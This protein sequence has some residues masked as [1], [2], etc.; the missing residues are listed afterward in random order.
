MS[1][2][3]L[4]ALLGRMCAIAEAVNAFKSETVQQ[5]AFD[6]LVEAFHGKRAMAP[7]PQVEPAEE[8]VG[9]AEADSTPTDQGKS[10]VKKPARRK[11]SGSSA[12]GFQMVKELDLRPAGK[13][14]FADFIA[15]KQPGSNE[16]KYA[17]A[18]YYLQH[19]LELPTVTTN[20]VATV[21]RLESSWREPQDALKGLRVTSSRKGTV[22]VAAA[23][24]LKMTPQGR[25]FVEHDL[26]RADKKTKK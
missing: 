14:S 5:A 17:V 7:V 23:D 15:E 22:D 8:E 26:P 4:D 19:V 3:N 11:S 18:V 13:V 21:F 10:A 20:H 9:E 16:D 1:E 6:A 25:N 12:R 2:Q 24:N